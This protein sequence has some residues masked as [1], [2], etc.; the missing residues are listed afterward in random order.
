MGVAE[1]PRV[2]PSRRAR[3][4]LELVGGLA[5]LG[6]CDVE[7]L[8]LVTLRLDHGIQRLLLLNLQSLLVFHK[9]YTHMIT[10]FDQHAFAVLKI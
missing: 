10:V 7:L 4:R 1:V 8:N 2:Q 9:L 5:D 3:G 6:T